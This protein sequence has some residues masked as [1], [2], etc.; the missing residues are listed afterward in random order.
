MVISLNKQGYE[1]FIDFL[2]GWA[3]ICVVITHAITPTIHDCT[4]FF[5][6]GDWAV[7]LFLMIQVFH[8]YKKGQPSHNLPWAKMVKRIII[9]FAA[10]TF[11]MYAI[12]CGLSDGIIVDY[13]NISKETFLAGGIGPGSYYPWIYI[14]F[15][16]IL[17]VLYNTL[18]NIKFNWGGYLVV[19]ILLE[20]LCSMIDMPEYIYR[21]SFVRYIFLVYLGFTWVENGIVINW[22]T[23][24]L[25]I[26]SI[27][28][29]TFFN[30]SNA[31]LEPLFFTSGW[32]ICHWVCYFY[33]ATLLVYFIKKMFDVLPQ[34]CINFTNK[35]GRYSYE[36]FLWQ[37]FVFTFVM[38]AFHKIEGILDVPKA[39]HLIGSFNMLASI[40]ISICPPLLYNRY[41]RILEK[42]YGLQ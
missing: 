37:M 20:A 16:I 12:K 30:F 31:D 34:Q 1:P 4:L 2:K 42:K 21:L 11:V 27:A 9:P 18:S 25:S 5:L 3:I 17:P 35:C 38:A 32:K 24:L 22:K 19:S 39:Y 36:I 13:V 6:W 14:Q 29:I 28:A 8:T 23:I 7:P 26:I 10:I 15:F 40:V 41:K 33:P